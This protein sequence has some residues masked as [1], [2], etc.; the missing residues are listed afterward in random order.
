M[1]RLHPFQGQRAAIATMHGKER[2]VAPLLAQWFGLRLERAEGVDTDALGTFTG[3]IER[4]G[5][6]LDAARAKAQLAIERTGARLGLGSEGAF[7]PHPLM[8]MIPSGLELM[9][10]IDS[11]TNHEIAVHLRT[12]T[13]Y[14][15]TLAPGG[16][17][18]PF[19]AR[20]GFPDHAVIV[21]PQKGAERAA[22]VKGLVAPQALRDAID[23]MAARSVTRKALVQTDMRA[24]LN[25]TRM[26]AI[27]HVTKALA[28]RVARLCPVCGSPGFGRVKVKRGLP[29][30]E[31][32]S[33]TDLVQ[34]EVHAC[35]RCGYRE[36]KR[37]RPVTLRADP[38]WC[39]LCNP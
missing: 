4:N 13:N 19:L 32:G 28:L 21:R 23:A 33:P 3:E 16:D 17:L 9:V 20:V 15:S 26:R 36:D 7:G 5:S 31:C 24:H 29:C 38:T 11:E 14:D 39:P 27:T 22:V 30:R 12:S 8:P 35:G 1:A 2:V 10:L 18:S 34:A 6:M 37:Q 25:P